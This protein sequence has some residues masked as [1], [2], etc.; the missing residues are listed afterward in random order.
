MFIAA[1]FLC[2][3][4]APHAF[5]QSGG[6][7]VPLTNIPGLTNIQPNTGGLASFFNNLYKYLIGLSAA[8]AVIMI[9]WQG[10]RISLNQDNVSVVTDSKGKIYNA[11]FGLVLVL[12]PVLVFSII[13]PSI[14]NLSVNFQKLDNTAATT[15]TTNNDPCAQ[16]P[17]SCTNTGG[18]Q[19]T[20]T[21]YYPCTN[22]NCA[23][24]RTLCAKNTPDGYT[25]S[26]SP[27]CLK[28]DGTLDP[29]GVA[30]SDSSGI[31]SCKAGD[32]LNISCA[33]VN[34]SST[35]GI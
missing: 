28:S 1:L 3:A 22:N 16:N 23:S 27:V 10:I 7:F 17:S 19:T 2:M 31:T 25:E 24:A 4:L 35:S 21:T 30:S 8:L 15:T 5:A 33:Y 6:T 13:N 29:N 34:V 14:L 32:T 20:G 9:T 11:I 26:D 18:G 12:S